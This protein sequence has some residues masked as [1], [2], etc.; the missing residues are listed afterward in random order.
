[1]PAPEFEITLTGNGQG[2]F[3]VDG[4]QLGGIHRGVVTFG[5]D[6]SPQLHLDMAG[7]GSI[8]GALRATLSHTS[9][10]ALMRLGWLPP[11]DVTPARLER[12]AAEELAEQEV[13]AT[14]ARMLRDIRQVVASFAPPDDSGADLVDTVMAMKEHIERLEQAAADIESAAA[15]YADSR[16]SGAGL[17][18]VVSDM[19]DRIQRLEQ[20]AAARRQDRS[21]VYAEL[22][23]LRVDL[24]NAVNN[25]PADDYG[26][27][28]HVRLLLSESRRRMP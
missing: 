13:H 27:L 3:K 10:K 1:M 16:E 25:D 5:V 7:S 24:D 6:D 8:I 17:A 20:V 19:N 15:P 9:I 18:T 23:Q 11:T 22:A 28:R 14:C 4:N 12:I 26:P 2:A 21:A